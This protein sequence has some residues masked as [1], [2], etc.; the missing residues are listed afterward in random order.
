MARGGRASESKGEVRTSK[1]VGFETV[2]RHL[3]YAQQD[4]G[5][6]LARGVWQWVAVE[7]PGAVTCIAHSWSLCEEIVDEVSAL[8]APLRR[9]TSRRLPFGR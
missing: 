1:S 5:S 3:G 8:V 2:A 4:S 9:D 6:R 7:G